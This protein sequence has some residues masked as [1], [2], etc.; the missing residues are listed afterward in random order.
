M[1]ER[2]DTAAVDRPAVADA[3]GSGLDAATTAPTLSMADAIE[4]AQTC[5]LAGRADLIA[6][7]LAS[8][9]APAQVRHQLLSAQAEASPE[10]SSRIAPDAALSAARNPLI[11]AAKRLAQ[12]AGKEI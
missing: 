1:N 7:F 5:Q 10:I 3:A 4:I 6:S 8:N 2:T 12:P 11:D 9:T